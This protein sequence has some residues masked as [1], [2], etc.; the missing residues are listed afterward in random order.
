[1]SYPTNFQLIFSIISTFCHFSLFVICEAIGN[2]TIILFDRFTPKFFKISKF[3]PILMKFNL[4][5]AKDFVYLLFQLADQ[6][7]K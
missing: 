6:K 3:N 1:M 7:I 2:C 5:S 4:K